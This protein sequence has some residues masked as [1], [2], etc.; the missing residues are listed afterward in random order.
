MKQKLI[1]VLIKYAQKIS[2]AREG[3]EVMS[4][5]EDCLFKTIPRLFEEDGNKYERD[6]CYLITHLRDLKKLE[7]CLL[8]S[9]I[10]LSVEAITK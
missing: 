4:C 10:N 3:F 8:A 9:N 2:C 1:E 7:G 5:E 6:L